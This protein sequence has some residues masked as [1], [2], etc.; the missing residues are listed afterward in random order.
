MTNAKC[1]LDKLSSK[2]HYLTLRP[3]Q[4]W[5]FHVDLSCSYCNLTATILKSAILSA[6]YGGRI[7]VSA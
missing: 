7:E 6:P 2:R 3:G 1:Y 5:G 4:Y